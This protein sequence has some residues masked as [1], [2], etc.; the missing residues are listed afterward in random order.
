M[1]RPTK[2]HAL[3]E[4]GRRVKPRKVGERAGKVVSMAERKCAR[5]G[6]TITA[7]QADNQSGHC[8]DCYRDFEEKVLA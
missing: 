3:V 2:V 5:C 8:D 4:K 7:F 6:A 1:L